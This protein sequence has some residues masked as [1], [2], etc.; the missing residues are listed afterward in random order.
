MKTIINSLLFALLFSSCLKTT[1]EIQKEQ[2]VEQQLAQGQKF[3]KD[4][5][6]Q[7]QTLQSTVDG[8]QGRFE[9]IEH[10]QFQQTQD[11]DEK[12]KKFMEQINEQMASLKEMASKN[13]QSI[14]SLEK[15]VDQQSEFIKKVTKSLSSLG[16]SGKSKS[17]KSSAV[18]D[19]EKA[20]KLF[21]KNKYS[22]AQEIYEELISGKK[23]GAAKNNA[24]LLNLGIIEYKKKNY[25]D[26]L[27]HLSKIY[28]K[29]PRSSKSPSALYHIGLCFQALKQQDEA[30]ETFNKVMKQYSKSSYADQAKKQLS[31]L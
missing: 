11:S 24:A 19:L 7:I 29:W 22:D 9:E 2:R 20:D 26:A 16:G 8:Y 18:D 23:L 28:T 25:N 15:Q 12:L 21:S 13:Q 17:S 27:V 1:E 14:S 10:K 6:V 31:S 5:L 4:F 3:N 30:R